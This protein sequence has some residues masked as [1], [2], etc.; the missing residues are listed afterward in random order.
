M[1]HETQCALTSGSCPCD[2]HDHAIDK[3][4]SRFC[5]EVGEGPNAPYPGMIAA[6][7][8]YYGQSFK[9]KDWRTEASVW[10]AAWKA[11]HRNTES[12]R[13]E[14]NRYRWLRKEWCLTLLAKLF[15]TET[16][17]ERG[18]TLDAKIDAAIAKERKDYL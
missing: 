1:E 12:I 11:G 6:F 3:A 17:G 18:A 10:A 13:Q 5:A 15:G 4:W 8:Q 14:A 7:E 9:D 16:Y 2:P